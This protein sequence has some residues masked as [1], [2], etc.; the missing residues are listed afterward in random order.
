ML[1][2]KSIFPMNASK[3][4]GE[5]AKTSYLQQCQ[6]LNR[7][8]LS[9]CRIRLWFEEKTAFVTPPT[10]FH[11]SQNN[12]I[13]GNEDFLFNITA[14]SVH[15]RS[16]FWS[17]FGHFSRNVYCWSFHLKLLIYIWKWLK[18]ARWLHHISVWKFCLFFTISAS[19]VLELIRLVYAAN[20]FD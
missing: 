17:V 12:K 8:C 4:L 6:V 15:L 2:G 11:P 16:F 14:W 18:W 20:Q 10:S 3:G 9:D 7:R 19:L 1:H 5:P 13:L